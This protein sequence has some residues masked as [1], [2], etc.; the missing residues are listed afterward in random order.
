LLIENER[1]RERMKVKVGWL[2]LSCLIVAGL[3]L[4]SC[5]PAEEAEE[6][7]TITGKV[8]E[9]EEKVV[10]KEEV[11]PEEGPKMIRNAAGVMEEEPNYGGTITQ[12]G[13]TTLIGFDPAYT[14]TWQ[15]FQMTYT[16]DPLLMG[17][18]SKSAQGTGETGFRLYTFML[19]TQAGFLAESYELPD[20]E[21]IIFHLR[22]GIHWQ[23]LPPVNGREFVADDV[24]Y[25]FKRLFEIPESY[26]MATHPEGRRPLS[27]EATDKYTVEIKVPA[28]CQGAIFRDLSSQTRP[29]APEIVKMYG[30][31][32]DWKHNVG[33][34][35]FILTDWVPHSSRN[36]DK[37]PD[38]W[39]EDP[40]LP[41]YKLPFV[42]HWK[43]LYIPDRSTRLSALRTGKVDQFP[44]IQMEDKLSL[45]QTNPELIY[46]KFGI[47]EYGIGMKTDKAPFNDIRVR[48]A[49]AL[50]MDNESIANDLYGGDASLLSYPV[51][52]LPD[53]ANAYVPL[54]ELP[55]STRELYG[56][57]LEKAKQLM[58]EAGYPDGFKAK[59]VS[60]SDVDTLVDLSE[61]L[62]EQWSKIGVDLEI[63]A[64]D[65]GAYTSV[66]VRFQH[67]DMILADSMWT[68]SPYKC[69]TWGTIDQAR[70]LS[71]VEDP[72]LTEKYEEIQAN[73]LQPEV[74]AA[75]L[76]EAVPF[77]LDK[78][79]YIEPPNIITSVFWQPWLKR[80]HGEY[81]CGYTQFNGWVRYCWI[82]QDLK[83]EMGH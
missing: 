65:Y 51:K 39:M 33:T 49:L 34:G 16:H 32:K 30:D 58:A 53:F 50:A 7:K 35:P 14:V 11:A 26:L 60:R 8:V 45:I 40:L 6:G 46:D 17:D 70:N 12:A 44:A 73:F 20:E 25:S 29:I 68:S 72:W 80:Y 43:Y 9:K 36:Y 55:E 52:E 79:W 69:Q 74:R 67:E 78:A 81:C 41:G 13:T 63:E 3:V 64:M 5:A 27:I 19:D 1:R 57:D 18:W 76:K 82:D 54:E 38:Y 61:V 47:N 37:N 21:T 83:K 15:C 48:R 59:M 28:G 62:K 77:I 71:R 42:D 10:E 56:Y 23:D 66:M 31:H 24:V 22:K 2:I 75:A 4:A